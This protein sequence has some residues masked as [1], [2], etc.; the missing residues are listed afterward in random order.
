M[1]INVNGP[2]TAPVYR[3]LKSATDNAAIG[4]DVCALVRVCM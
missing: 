2:D 3:Y 4:K 1:Q